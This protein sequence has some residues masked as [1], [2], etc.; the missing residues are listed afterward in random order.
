MTLDVAAKVVAELTLPLLFAISSCGQP[1]ENMRQPVTQVSTCRHAIVVCMLLSF[2]VLDVG[3]DGVGSEAP[4]GIVELATST[5]VR[6]PLTRGEI[7]A[8]VPTSRAQ[9]HFPAPYGTEAFRITLPGDCG[10]Q[11]CVN[12]VGY[13]YWRNLN[14]HT[15]SD[16][17]YL[18][19]GLD[20][21]K[22]GA[23]PTLFS[24]NKTTKQVARVGPLFGQSD[25]RSWA[26]GEGW[27]F[28]A[29]SPTGLYMNAGPRLLRYDVMTH[30]E[31]TV[32][33]ISTRPDLYGV[34]AYVWQTHT[35]YNDSVHSFSVKGYTDYQSRGCGV[36]L[37]GANQYRFFPSDPLK[38]DECQIDSS[39]RWLIIKE[40]VDGL[41]GVDTR[42]IDLEL[43][44]EVVQLNGP[45]PGGG[46]G[47]SDLGFGYMIEADNFYPSGAAFKLWKFGTNP[48]GPGTVVYSDPTWSSESVY[49]VTHLN[50]ASAGPE[51]QYSCGSGAE[52]RQGPRV[53]EIVC[54]LLDGSLKT[55]VVAPVMTSLDAPGGSDDY[56]KLPKGNIDVT[57]SYFVWTSNLGGVRQDAFL[58]RVPSQL[59]V[60][61]ISPTLS[62][63]APGG[64]A[65]VR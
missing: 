14:N 37:A 30:G 47:H 36:Y 45:T 63:R 50:S 58:V 51:N 48:L 57:G 44:T 19:L 22:G 27:Y 17:I 4:G 42:I 16:T 2:G 26:S 28:S 53:G 46:G 56:S 25:S 54:F 60:A 5:A 13:A 61:G 24:V 11:D 55:L 7:D 23:G 1:A 41:R 49:H 52:R 8:L 33:D 62:I 3:L 32:L 64:V 10:G 15:S 59:L 18:F 31:A 40:Q 39:G 6:S 35:S 9:F 43:N 21:N 12:S 34:G 29:V 65:I 38:Y 20:R